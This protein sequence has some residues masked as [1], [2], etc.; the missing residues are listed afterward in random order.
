MN[1][2][3]K[4]FLSILFFY[5]IT[6]LLIELYLGHDYVRHY[7]TDM[8]G[9]VLL[10][11]L[12][13]TITT[14]LLLIISYNFILT[15]LF[16]KGI[17]GTNKQFKFYFVIQAVLFLYLAMD[18]RFMLHERIGYVLG[19]H[20]AFPLMSVGV[21]ELAVLFYFKELQIYSIKW[22]SP[23]VLGAICFAIMVIIDVFA[24]QR[25]LLR[26]SFEDLFKLWGIFFLFRYSCNVYKK[27]VHP[28][29]NLGIY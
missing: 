7:L 14:V 20:D 12:H 5:S 21:V 28:V 2:R 27:W 1:S 10:W 23:L 11:G 18:E 24:P 19:I 4:W 29:I 25:A 22:N 3:L 13:T 16:A 26:I 17:D 9:P 15:F 6:I 8:K